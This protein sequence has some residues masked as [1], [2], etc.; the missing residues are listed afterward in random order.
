MA[1]SW[2]QSSSWFHCQ[3][4]NLWRLMGWD[5]V[6]WHLSWACDIVVDEPCLSRQNHGILQCKGGPFDSLCP[7]PHKVRHLQFF[8]LFFFFYL[9][10]NTLSLEAF[11]MRICSFLWG[12][13]VNTGCMT[14]MLLIPLG[15]NLTSEFHILLKHIIW[16]WFC[17]WVLI[18]ITLCM[19]IF[20]TPTFVF[21]FLTITHSSVCP[22]PAS[23]LLS[24]VFFSNNRCPTGKDFPLAWSL[25]V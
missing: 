1:R 14:M 20:I 17:R 22:P 5:T 10:W 12:G 6:M 11:H 7:L 9:Y 8:V 4:S 2:I 25:W 24:P 15:N 23:C 19:I 3:V 13:G 18:S 16:R 21:C